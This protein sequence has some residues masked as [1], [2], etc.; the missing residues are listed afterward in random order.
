MLGEILIKKGLITQEDLDLALRSRPAYNE[1]LVQ[2]LVRLG[3]TTEDRICKAISEQLNLPYI[4]VL[5]LT[6]DKSILE[7]I[8]VKTIFDKKILP[9]S[10]ETGSI[11]V[12]ASD[13]FDLNTVDEL[14]LLLKASIKQVIA[15]PTDIETKV[16][17]LFG[18][19]ADEVEKLVLS[20]EDSS[21]L[22]QES[23]EQKD[24]EMAEDASL[25]KFV[26]QIMTQAAKDGSSDIHIEPFEDELQIRFR[27]DGVLHKLPVPPQVNK[28]RAAIVSR[29]K[30]MADLNIAEK[31]LPQDGAIQ[32]KINGREIDVRVSII[33]GIFGEGVVL[34][35]LDRDIMFLSL[36]ELGMPQDS[37]T[38]YKVIIDQPYGIFLV[39]GPTGSGKTTTLYAS[40]QKINSCED[41][42][43][44]IED[45][46]EYK[47]SGIKQI[48]V[49]HKIGLTFANG[50][51]SI[52]RHDPDII[53]VGEIR[54][55]ETAEISI[56][57]ALTGHLVFSTLHTNDA[58][59]A[60][61]RLIDMGVE[62][63]L[64]ASTV[65]GVMA[66][67]LVRT[68][69]K[70]CITE[71]KREGTFSQLI[72]DS[73]KRFKRGSGCERCRYTGYKGRTGIFELMTMTDELKEMI[74]EK[75]SS[76]RLKK[77]VMSQ[78]MKSLRDS[79][80]EKVKAGITTP[81][82]VLRITKDDR[83]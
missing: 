58:P 53:M 73:I 24:I 49:N 35:L 34:R 48:Q 5:N 40:L 18:V 22:A 17:E 78:G 39:T 45:P 71:V 57:S 33:P 63:Y 12:A 20:H 83:F 52:L 80:W 44:T 51:R 67:R 79:G 81:E 13:P 42:I 66:Q 1:K 47:L 31:R 16:K 3:M 65:E 56:Q 9:I 8:P 62:P 64:V 28:F 72:P 61:T 6:I 11:T 77:Q 27:I 46:V 38:Q 75:E 43:I 59:S 70:S 23:E 2:T 68:I 82:E 25:I 10:R 55:Y 60:L 14:R 29:I 50:L 4:D 69:C 30:I 26:N 41:K 19:A 74:L 54:D 15:K 76:S 32:I 21:I 37:Y 7:K 36:E